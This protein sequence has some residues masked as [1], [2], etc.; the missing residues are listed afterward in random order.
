MTSSTPTITESK[1]RSCCSGKKNKPTEQKSETLP[2][3]E[4]TPMI[5]KE[6]DE[7]PKG[8]QCCSSNNTEPESDGT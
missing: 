7:V 5:I 2:K 8:C 4:I 6:V 3:V 1:P